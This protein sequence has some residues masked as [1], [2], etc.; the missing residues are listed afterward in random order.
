MREGDP[1]VIDILDASGTQFHFG[2]GADQ[3]DGDLFAET[4][5]QP[6]RGLADTQASQVV[7]W[8]EFSALRIQEQHP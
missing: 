8:F 3:R 5:N 1:V 6:G 7:R 4:L 2:A